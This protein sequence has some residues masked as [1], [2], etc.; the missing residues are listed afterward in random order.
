MASRAP[1][2]VASPPHLK[3]RVGRGGRLSSKLGTVNYSVDEMRR[4]NAKVRAVL[5]LVGEDW[6]HVA[7]QFNYLRPEAIPY[8]EVESLK[9]KF[10]KMYCSRGSE[11]K[12][13]DYI[14]EAK[15]LRRL[16]N[17]RSD[18]ADETLRDKS[19]SNSNS[20][21]GLAISTAEAEQTEEENQLML[22]AEE[23]ARRKTP[24]MNS[25]LQEAET[26]ASRE[27]AVKLRQMEEEYHQSLETKR[28]GSVSGENDGAQE[29]AEEAATAAAAEHAVT[30]T[31]MQTQSGS[32]S[33]WPEGDTPTSGVIAMLR[34]SVERKKRTIEEQML[35]ESERVRRERKK[36]KMEQVFLSYHREQRERE[37]AGNG[38]SVAV[39]TETSTPISTPPASSAYANQPHI[40]SPNH[41]H[42]PFTV[43]S[44]TTAPPPSCYP[45]GGLNQT[46]VGQ[47]AS[48]LGLM[49]LLL[50]FMTAQQ[51]ENAQRVEGEQARRELERREREE[52]RQKKELQ[53]RQDH[54]ELMLTMAAL[55]GNR[56]PEA[57]RHYLNDDGQHQQQ[58]PPVS[59]IMAALA[60]GQATSNVTE[61][62]VTA[63]G[64]PP[65]PVSTPAIATERN[66]FGNEVDVEEGAVDEQEEQEADLDIDESTS[67]VL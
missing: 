53:R 2:S 19:N 65:S 39:E 61:D 21:N 32:T 55:L 50:Q 27:I 41:Q 8:R 47:D 40:P 34:Q 62:T 16:I 15:E 9:R 29:R 23:E 1:G 28:P 45:I 36:R 31:L 60:L 6:L 18:K 51:L 14:V 22:T 43:G 48:S 5:P 67:A 33:G 35:S 26:E 17:Q 42:P 56:F 63:P 11:G 44:T 59:S 58:T 46:S 57:L 7:Y 37:I 10:K 54:R 20:S 25:E 66:D 24:V 12:L 38:T 30:A 4:L 49:E 3:P 52:R 64:Q 13:A